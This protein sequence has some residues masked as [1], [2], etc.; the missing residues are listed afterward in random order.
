MNLPTTLESQDQP[1]TP[2]HPGVQEGVQDRSNLAQRRSFWWLWLLILGAAGYGGYRWYTTSQAAQQAAA[3]QQAARA[4]NRA[5]PVVTAT[6]R[7]GDMP[8]YLRGI[9]SV[10][11]F[12]TVTVKA[13]VDGQITGVAFKEGQFVHQG[14]LLVQI[15]PRPY[16]VVLEQMQGQLARD[17][18]QLKDAQ[19]NLDRDQT[20]WQQQVIPKQQLDTQAA[21]VGQFQGT[22]DADKANI[23]SAKLQ[24]TYAKVTAPISGVI[25]L[26]LVDGGNI[27]HAT[28]VNG[29][30]VITQLQPISVIFTIPADNLQPI[31]KKLHAG[32]TLEV[33][34]YD[35]DDRTRLASGTLLT[36]DNQIDQTTGTSRLKATFSNT[37]G[38][39]FPNQFVNCRLLLDTL[40][41]VTIIPVPALQSGPQGS[42]VYAVT[43]DKKASV[44][45][46]TLGITEGS[47]V[48]VTSGVKPGDSLITDGQDKLQ[49]GT[50]VDARAGGVGAGRRSGRAGAGGASPSS[51]P[52][53]DETGR[54]KG[55][56]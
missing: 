27:V 6:A 34:A 45:P 4:A 23:D 26:R 48:I 54:K 29:L 46:V 36:V 24:L 7:S 32:A 37:D 16:Q 49:E 47:E 38:A 44:R 18:A 40:H 8:V 50:R 41:G 33:D 22:I 30:A 17:Q 10:T 12:N 3:T 55:R 42:F 53:G 56:Q 15:D 1:A 2:K 52:K 21:S 39:L 9:G 31:L 35:R 19:V 11:A 28:D 13:R 43:P 20:L 14:D 25:G 51:A 5:V